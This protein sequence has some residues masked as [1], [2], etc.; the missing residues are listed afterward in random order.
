MLLIDGR[1]TE[2]D[3]KG[4]QMARLKTNHPARGAFAVCSTGSTQGRYYQTKGHAVNAFDAALRSCNLHL[5]CD[6]LIDFHNDDGRKVVVVHDCIDNKVGLAVFVW[7]RM[8]SG[9]YEFI[10]YLA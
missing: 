2:E 3:T 1:G 10:G 8:K 6:D 5:D 9:R 4:T 7:H